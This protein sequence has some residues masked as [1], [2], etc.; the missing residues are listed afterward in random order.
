MVIDQNKEGSRDGAAAQRRSCH[1]MGQ[2]FRKGVKTAATQ[3]RS[4]HGM[5][6]LVFLEQ[7][8]QSMEFQP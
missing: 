1:A 4:C 5:Q 7:Q 8:K 2:R 3:R 6:L